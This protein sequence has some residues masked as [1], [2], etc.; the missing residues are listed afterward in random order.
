MTDRSVQERIAL[1][2]ENELAGEVLGVAVS[3]VRGM[4]RDS[5]WFVE[6]HGVLLGSEFRY[7]GYA[8]A[9]GWLRNLD[10]VTVTDPFGGI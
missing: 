6:A 10:K 5:A 1:A 3:P 4:G 9:E 8:T 2:V 7:S